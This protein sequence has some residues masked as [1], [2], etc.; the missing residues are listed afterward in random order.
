[1]NNPTKNKLEQTVII[2]A[3]EYGIS[4]TL[5]RNT[6]GQRLG[7]NDTDMQC[8][9]LLFLKEV[10]TPTELSKH[11]SLSTGATTAMLDRL[12]RAKLIRREP[13]PNDRR[14][15]L[16]QVD[17]SSAK[18]VGPLFAGTR[19]AQNE[20]VA[21]YSETELEIIADFFRR[22]TDIWDEGREKLTGAH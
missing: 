15:V 1:M 21:S 12:E 8:L 9:G 4:T 19:A 20:L 22:F 7:L 6:V 11:T 3:R 2:A 13:N 5:F 18:T 17:K 16:V 10:S 14:G